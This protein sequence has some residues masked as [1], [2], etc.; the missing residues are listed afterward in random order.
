MSSATQMPPSPLFQPSHSAR[1]FP[2]SLAHYGLATVD[3]VLLVH[4]QEQMCWLDGGLAGGC[5]AAV[6]VQAIV[7]RGLSV[8]RPIAC[9][10]DRTQIAA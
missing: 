3:L 1:H 9:E 7:W 10:G 6:V 4:V 5:G 2:L 8:I